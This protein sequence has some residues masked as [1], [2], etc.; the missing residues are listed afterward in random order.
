VPAGFDLDQKAQLVIAGKDLKAVAGGVN[1]KKI[2]QSL[3]LGDFKDS[4]R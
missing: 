2:S 3:L 1:G 4:P